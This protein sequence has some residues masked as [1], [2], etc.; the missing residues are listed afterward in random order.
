MRFVACVK[1]IASEYIFFA[2]DWTK[3]PS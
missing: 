1:K 3:D 2:R